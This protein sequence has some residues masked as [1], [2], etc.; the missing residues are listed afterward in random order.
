[1]REFGYVKI[2]SY[3]YLLSIMVGL[4]YKYA[5]N[6]LINIAVYLFL[7]FILFYIIQIVFYKNL[8]IKNY[9]EMFMFC[10]KDI[11]K[12]SVVFLFLNVVIT[13]VLFLGIFIISKKSLFQLSALSQYVNFTF[14]LFIFLVIANF[15]FYKTYYKNKYQDDNSLDNKEADLIEKEVIMTAKEDTIL[16]DIK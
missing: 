9:N 2:A 4:I 15:I 7:V 3:F 8:N 6:P 5:S 1:M 16:K 12:L 14:L 10:I 11:I 13:S